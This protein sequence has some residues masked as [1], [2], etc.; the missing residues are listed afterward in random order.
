MGKL[1][2]GKKIAQDIFLQWIIA[3]WILQGRPQHWWRNRLRIFEKIIAKVGFH[4]RIWNLPEIKLE[5]DID[6]VYIDNR[7]MSA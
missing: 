5:T 6:W 2:R 7:V 4:W 3:W 1:K